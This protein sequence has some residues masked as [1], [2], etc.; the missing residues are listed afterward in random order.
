MTRSQFKSLIIKETGNSLEEMKKMKQS[1]RPKVYTNHSTAHDRKKLSVLNEMIRK[2]LPHSTNTTDADIGPIVH[3]TTIG[4]VHSKEGGHS[5]ERRHSKDVSSSK[6]GSAIDNTLLPT[7]V[8]PLIGGG[9]NVRPSTTP[10]QY[11]TTPT[12]ATPT[13]NMTMPTNAPST[14][15]MTTPTNASPLL[16][17]P[18]PLP[19]LLYNRPAVPHTAV[20][21]SG[22]HSNRPHPPTKPPRSPNYY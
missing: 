3:D 5:K 4:G 22:Y 16:S 1:L 7:S 13:H 21:Y 6:E 15:Y 10:T 11:M 17:S 20:L 18:P 12:S 8:V 19:S 9:A 2:Q 14:L